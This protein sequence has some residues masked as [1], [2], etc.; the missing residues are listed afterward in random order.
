MHIAILSKASLMQRLSCVG[1]FFLVAWYQDKN[2]GTHKLDGI[3]SKS[4][5]VSLRSSVV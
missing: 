1:K 4:V 3:I 5:A 2:V